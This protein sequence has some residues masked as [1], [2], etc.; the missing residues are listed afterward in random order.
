MKRARGSWPRAAT[1][2]LAALAAAA[3]SV[4]LRAQAT[5]QSVKAAFLPKF[6][7]YVVWPAHAR[8]SGTDPT[9]L[10]IIGDDPFGR[11]LHA[12]TEGQRVGESPIVVRRLSTADRASGCHIA[13]VRGSA[14]QTTSQMLLALR[15]L[16]V[17]TITDARYGSQ[18]G[19]IHFVPNQGRVGFVID[20]AAAASS[21]L[22]ISSRLLALAVGVRARG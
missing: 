3:P 8:P 13:F 22:S 5:E 1:L 21:S 11:L 7:R 18:R 17:L 19:M 2:L 10:C 6:A 4:P 12:A 20:D 16:P 15:P 14:A 9:I